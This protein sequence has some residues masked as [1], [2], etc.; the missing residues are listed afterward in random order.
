MNEWE[1]LET[2]K[3]VSVELKNMVLKTEPASLID[4]GTNPFW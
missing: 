4:L 1:G 3:V 2:V